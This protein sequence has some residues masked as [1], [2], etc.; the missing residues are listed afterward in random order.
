MAC[1]ASVEDYS[2]RLEYMVKSVF[3]WQMEDQAS[4]SKDFVYI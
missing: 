4:F 2:K 1:L 3:T